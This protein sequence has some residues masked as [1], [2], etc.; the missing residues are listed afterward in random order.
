VSY[1]DASDLEE[2]LV[3]LLTEA[4]NGKFKNVTADCK[5]FLEISFF[6]AVFFRCWPF[7]LVVF[8]L[9]FQVVDCTCFLIMTQTLSMSIMNAIVQK[10]VVYASFIFA[11]NKFLCCYQLCKLGSNF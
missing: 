5:K 4:K 8:F 9:K 11:L 2:L 7:H 1:T 3:W 10:H 6:T